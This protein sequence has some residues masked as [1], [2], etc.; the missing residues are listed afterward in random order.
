MKKVPLRPLKDRV[1]IFPD[2]AEEVSEGGII[3][4]D[5]ARQRPKKGIVVA[6]GPGYKDLPN[7][8]V[9]GD[10]VWY[11]K[12]AGDEIIY[13]DKTYLIM[14]ENDVILIEPAEE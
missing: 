8:T 7:E 4:P 9:P 5:S 2:A 6:S 3:I 13:D 1:I 14:H 10:R 11:G 12:F